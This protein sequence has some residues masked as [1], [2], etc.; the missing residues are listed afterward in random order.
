[1]QRWERPDLMSILVL[2]FCVWAATDKTL[3]EKLGSQLKDNES[4]EMNKGGYAFAIRH[5]AGPISYQGENLLEKNKD[6]L[7]N[8][9]RLSKPMIDAGVSA[10]VWHSSSLFSSA[11]LCLVRWATAWLRQTML[12]LA[13]SF[14]TTTWPKCA[15]RLQAGCVV[16][17]YPL[18]HN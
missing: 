10:M 7:P 14:G 17:H 15:E 18:V 12:W 8:R 1:M 3:L 4:F 9:V 16:A 6:P 13:C 11:T 5:F 2:T